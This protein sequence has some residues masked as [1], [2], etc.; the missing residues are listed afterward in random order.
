MGRGRNGPATSQQAAGAGG[1]G[2]FNTRALVNILFGVDPSTP[3]DEVLST[4]PQALF[5]MNSSQINKAIEAGKGTVLGEILSSTPDNRAALEALYLR[6]LSRRP[7][8]KEVEVC[9]RYLQAVGDR[10]EAFEDILWSLINST[11]F[12]SRR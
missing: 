5:L 8:P 2:R 9:G 6:V 11:E 7:S 12:V 3:N 4:I 10:R 1:R